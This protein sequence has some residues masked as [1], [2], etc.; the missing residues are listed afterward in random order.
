[1]PHISSLN[2][3]QSTIFCLDNYISS[4]NPVRIIDAFVNK[5]NLQALGSVTFESSKPGQQPYSRSDLLK[6][7][8]YGYISGIR[9]S[10]KLSAACHDSLSIIWL[11]G[12][13]TPSKSSITDFIKVNEIPIQNTFKLF[14][15]FLHHANYIDGEATVTDGTKIRAQNSRN[16]YYSIKKIDNTISYFNSQIEHYTALLKSSDSDSNS[17]ETSD[18][19]AIHFKEKISNYEKKI[20][21][22]TNLKKKMMDNGLSQITLTDPDSRMMTSHGNS[23]ICYNFQTSVDSKNSLIVAND[24]VSDV[25]DTN[26]LQN[27]HK[28]TTQNLGFAPKSNI[29]D[30]GYFNA[31]QIAFCQANGSQ[32]FVKRPKTKNAT[33]NSSFSIDKFKYVP[34]ENIYICPAGNKLHFSRNLVKRKNKNDS[35]TSILGYEYTCSDCFHCPHFGKCTN[36]LAGRKITRN[37]YQ[38]VLDKVQKNFEEKPDMYVLRKCVVEH[39]FGTIKRSLGYTY[40]LRRGLK[41]VRTEAALIC[42]AYDIKRL[43]NIAKVKEIIQ[44]VEEF[45][46]RLYYF[47]TNFFQFCQN[48][49]QKKS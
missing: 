15:E 29:A 12:G 45:F 27:M 18:E 16:R 39:P 40:F 13:I 19:E 14:V 24:V 30:M 49:R 34:E 7:H 35:E 25:N 37:Y 11:I 47:F 5:L 44:K 26:Q 2:R 38:D 17:S 6:L 28:K 31:E 10:R 8:L 1:M 42:L 33:N 32:V 48:F 36:S 9:S 4:D 22:F 43:A 41:A 23:D 3:N 46:L 20:D 21:E